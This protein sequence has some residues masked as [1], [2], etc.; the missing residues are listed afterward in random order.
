MTRRHRTA[1]PALHN[2]PITTIE[3][4]GKEFRKEEPKYIVCCRCGEGV[5]YGVAG[6]N[7]VER[8]DVPKEYSYISAIG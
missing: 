5:I 6:A 2:P 8:I 3:K 4:Q 1:G 7:L